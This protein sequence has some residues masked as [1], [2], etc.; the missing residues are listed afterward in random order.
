MS[1]EKW[2]RD[3]ERRSSEFHNLER[4]VVLAI[5]VASKLAPLTATPEMGGKLTSIRT[6]IEH[7][8]REVLIAVAAIEKLARETNKEILSSGSL[9]TLGKGLDRSI[10]GAERSI[11]RKLGSPGSVEK[12][13][14]SP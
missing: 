9:D 8:L 5:E 11:A 13:R 7:R 2:L 10:A 1:R 6:R 3:L 14:H 4:R 12:V